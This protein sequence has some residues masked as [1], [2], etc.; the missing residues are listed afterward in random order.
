MRTSALRVSL[1]YATLYAA[2]LAA[3]ILTVYL[4]TVRFIDAEVETAIERDVNALV[5]AY[6]ADGMPRLMEE[7]ELREGA[8][9]RSN[10]VYLLVDRRG[11]VLAGNLSAYPVMQMAGE[12]WVTFEFTTQVGDAEVSHPVRATVLELPGGERLLVGTDLSERQLLLR[13]FAVAAAVGAV[14]VTLLALL[15]GYGQSRRILARVE[16]VN[17]SCDDILGGNLSRRLPVAGANDEFDALARRVNEL[18]DRLARTTEILRASLHS[19][20]HDLR[21]PMHRMRLRLEGALTGAEPGPACSDALMGDLDHM[22]RVLSAL[23]QIAEAESGAMGAQPEEI[24]MDTMLAEL[25]ELYQP[26]AE[27]QG[28]TLVHEL[29]AGC[30]VLGHRQL[31][32]QAV[33]NLID[34]ALKYTPAGGLVTLRAVPAGERLAIQ[35]CDTGPGIPPAERGRA[36]TPFVRLGEGQD[37]GGSGLGLSLAAA[38][39]RLHG[40]A[41]RLEDNA[42]GLRAILEI[43][44]GKMSQGIGGGMPVANNAGQ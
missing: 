41:L 2:A 33:A 6:S 3:L 10:G 42:P 15:V 31:L 26:Q 12:K 8:F 43:P 30:R 35:V 19:A 11:S 38:V 7:V 27:E 37:G 24:P 17:S 29:P 16:A 28:I 13:R 34:N 23:L 4:L 18:L 32:A 14:L 25:G 20:A 5:E 44:C 22:Q 39:A 9:G 40:G 21:S 1:V 36:L